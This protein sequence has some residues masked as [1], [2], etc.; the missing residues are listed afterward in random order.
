MAKAAI[1]MRRSGRALLPVG[2]D[3]EARI[4]A[5]PPETILSVRISRPRMPKT[6]QTFFQVIAKA[7]KHWPPGHD[8]HP[9]DGDEEMLRAWLLC[10]VRY[11][12]VFDFPLSGNAVVD[13]AAVSGIVKLIERVRSEDT[14]AFVRQ[15]TVDGGPA[16]RAF[17]PK[18]MDWDTLDELDFRPIKDKVFGEIEHII[19][20]RIEDLLVSKVETA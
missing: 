3:D 12:D 4:L 18:S 9:A 13:A 19:G 10:R 11:C 14:F 2:A 5:L 1:Q 7:L 15:G 8:P 6:H 17:V 16:M 20:C